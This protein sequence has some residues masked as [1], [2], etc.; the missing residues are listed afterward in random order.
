MTTSRT[1]ALPGPVTEPPVGLPR[2]GHRPDLHRL[3]SSGFE[4]R[5][6]KVPEHRQAGQLRV[7]ST[8]VCPSVAVM[9]VGPTV[10]V[11]G[12]DLH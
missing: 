6:A 5:R 4:S 1:L 8:E 3:G 2:A 9:V 7:N 12:C 11:H 10:S